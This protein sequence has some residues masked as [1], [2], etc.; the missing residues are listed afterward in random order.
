MEQAAELKIDEKYL[1]KMSKQAMSLS[2][3]IKEHAEELINSKADV[4]DRYMSLNRL[5]AILESVNS[6]LKIAKNCFV[7]GH[8]LGHPMLQ[9]EKAIE[10]GWTKIKLEH[11][12]FFTTE[13]HE[14]KREFMNKIGGA[15]VDALKEAVTETKKELA[16]EVH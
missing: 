6:A 10:Y 11:D 4:F 15:L 12:D 9:T 7:T 8:N 16:P 1:N 3:F 14:K 2:N 5:Q 13:E